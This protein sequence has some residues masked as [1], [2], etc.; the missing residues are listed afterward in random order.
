MPI[1]AG[2]STW[3]PWPYLNILAGLFWYGV[4]TAPRRHGMG[5]LIGFGGNTDLFSKRLKI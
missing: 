4:N 3:G 2:A 1:G 5:A